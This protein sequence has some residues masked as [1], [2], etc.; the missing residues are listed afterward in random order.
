M[1]PT[2]NSIV[3]DITSKWECGMNGHEE[4]NMFQDTRTCHIEGP[5]LDSLDDRYVTDGL[6][7]DDVVFRLFQL[8]GRSRSHADGCTSAF[9][10]VPWFLSITRSSPC[11]DQN[12]CTASITP[13]LRVKAL[14]IRRLS[15]HI[16]ASRM[17]KLHRGTIVTTASGSRRASR[18]GCSLDRYNPTRARVAKLR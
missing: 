15:G 18:A 8:K 3:E 11:V 14:S 2:F 10:G 12:T 7:R 1:K 13:E 16:A 17:F 4:V 5:D 6:R 9:A